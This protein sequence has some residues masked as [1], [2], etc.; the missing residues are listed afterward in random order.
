VQ[1]WSDVGRSDIAMVGGKN[2][3]LD[4]LIDQLRDA[5]SSVPG[6]LR[7]WQRI[8]GSSSK[9]TILPG[10]SPGSSMNCRTTGAKD[11]ETL[12]SYRLKKT[13]YGQ[14]IQTA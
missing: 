4:E 10:N 2:A 1:W 9:P 13:A 12:K 8:T 3:S 6:G 7:R 14:K 11:A 5:G